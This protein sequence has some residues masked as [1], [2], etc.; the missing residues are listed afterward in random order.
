MQRTLIVLSLLLQ[1]SCSPQIPANT[2]IQGEVLIGPVCPV[3]QLNNPCPDKPYQAT[4]AILTSEGRK[5]MKVT[6][7][8]E[9]RF[10]VPLTPGNYILHPET[11][12]NQPMPFAA[13]Q[14]FRVAEGQ[15]TQLKVTYDRGIR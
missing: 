10:Q 6:S 13:E 3:V 14:F 11:P 8:A 12:P 7:N 2:G 5:I 1:V 15:F 9:G 4:L